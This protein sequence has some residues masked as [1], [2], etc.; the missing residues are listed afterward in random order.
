M[1]TRDDLR[2]IAL[3]EFAV[4]GYA[5]T[6]LQRIAEVAGVSK[7]NVLYHFD[8]KEALLE[9]AIG[10]AIDR[11]GVILDSID[12]S[13]AEPEPRRAFIEQFVDFL[14]AHRLEV[15]T[16]IS[17][18]PGLEDVPVVDRANELVAKLATFF[19]SAVSTVEDHLRFGIALGGAAY[20]LS[21]K[22][23]PA[24]AEGPFDDSDANEVRAA[25]VTIVSELLAPVSVQPA[26]SAAQ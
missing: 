21:A 5:G 10:P 11:M 7:S 2:D 15:H 3:K 19:S 13:L 17:Q 1:S 16:F 22:Q 8:S 6:S 20:V 14:L 12:G 4:A 26:H 24:M 9:A 18:G 23:D 25:L